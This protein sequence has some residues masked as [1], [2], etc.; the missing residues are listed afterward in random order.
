MHK[1]PPSHPKSVGRDGVQKQ[2]LFDIDQ[3]PAA[4]EARHCVRV[5]SL[6]PI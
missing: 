2:Q 4:E 1:Y 6:E 5:G 3:S